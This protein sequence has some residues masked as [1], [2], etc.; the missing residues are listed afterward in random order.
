MAGIKLGGVVAVGGSILGT[1]IYNCLIDLELEKTV[2]SFLH[3]FFILGSNF[4][5]ITQNHVY[6]IR[7]T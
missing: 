1:Q 7:K 3:N 2:H 6:T 4:M 5:K